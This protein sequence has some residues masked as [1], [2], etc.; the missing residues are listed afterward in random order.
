MA[1]LDIPSSKKMFF[2]EKDRYIR[3][4]L[5]M[6]LIIL[7]VVLIYSLFLGRYKINPLELLKMI[8]EFFTGSLKPGKAEHTWSVFYYIRLPRIIL[9][10][11]VGSILSVTG[12]AY[13]SIFRNPLISPGILGVSAGA[14]FGVALG[15]LLNARSFT[16]IYL[17]AFIMGTAA[18]LL[19]FFISSW[20]KGRGVMMMVLS[21]V[22]VTSL[23]N[24]LI[25]IIK[26]LAD[27]YDKLP[28]IVFWLMGGFSRTGWTEVYLILPFVIA[29][30]AVIYFLRWQLNILSLGEEEATSLG[31][32]VG[33]LRLIITGLSSLMLAGAVATSGQITWIGL[34]IPHIARYFVGADHRHVLPA[35]ALLGAAFLLLMDNIARSLTGAEIPISIIT[36]LIGAPFFAY[37][38]IYRRES[39]WN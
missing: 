25:S 24:A 39:G 13:Q 28:G 10:M 16:F 33:F 22:I 9:V 15:M 29:G 18:V 37:L 26:Y 21:G 3:R 38:L 17:S 32:E 23:F 2:L 11:M 30:L 34:V 19:T 35:S 4:R 5:Y 6:M 36:A 1:G 31:L 8:K 27:P 7:L 14:A 20:S 12:T